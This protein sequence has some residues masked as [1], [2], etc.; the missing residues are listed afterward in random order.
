[1]CVYLELTNVAT[2]AFLM[3]GTIHVLAGQ[4]PVNLP[5]HCDSSLRSFLNRQHTIY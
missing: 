4:G 5:H 1:M 2:E 3:R